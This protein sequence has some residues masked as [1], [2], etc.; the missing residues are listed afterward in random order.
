MRRETSNPDSAASTLLFGTAL[1]PLSERL[2][3]RDEGSGFL[4]VTESALFCWSRCT[5]K[6]DLAERRGGRGGR[7]KL[8]EERGGID[9]GVVSCDMSCD[10]CVG[11]G[12]CLFL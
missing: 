5:C 12:S 8:A 6:C 7:W 2:F 3:F 9:G 10:M 11:V 4:L 1:E